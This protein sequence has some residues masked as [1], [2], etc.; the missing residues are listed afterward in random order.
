MDFAQLNRADK[1]KL[2]EQFLQEEPSLL[3]D[4]LLEILQEQDIMP[5]QEYLERQKKLE[6]IIEGT[7]DKY[8]EV[9]KRLA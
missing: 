6:A 1:K 9:F 7:F 4:V 8:E 5:S 3:K 2:L